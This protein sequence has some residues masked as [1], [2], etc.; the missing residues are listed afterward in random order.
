MNAAAAAP[1]AEECSRSGRI[2]SVPASGPEAAQ[3][4]PSSP[5]RPCW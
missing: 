1:P 4:A 3:A 5:E 2:D